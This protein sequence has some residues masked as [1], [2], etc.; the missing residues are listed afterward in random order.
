MRITN[1]E[2]EIT[3]VVF[4]KWPKREGGDVIA[5]FPENIAVGYYCDSYQHVGQ[6]GAA[7]YSGVV[8]MTKPAKPEEYAALKREL[9][10]APYEYKL[11]VIRRY[12]RRT[13]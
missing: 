11:R 2:N 7:D 10:S 5:L 13:R 3:K 6:H 9:E 1:M 4:R 8:S 12:T